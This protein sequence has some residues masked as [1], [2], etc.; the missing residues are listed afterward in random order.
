MFWRLCIL[1][2]RED[3][4]AL[5]ARLGA[6]SIWQLQTV[7]NRLSGCYSAKARPSLLPA[8]RGQVPAWAAQRGQ[9]KMVLLLIKEGAEVTLGALT[10]A[11]KHGHIATVKILLAAGAPLRK[12]G[13]SFRNPLTEALVHGHLSIAKLLLGVGSSPIFHPSVL[14]QTAAKGHEDCVRLLL[15]LNAPHVT[16]E[17]ENPLLSLFRS[18]DMLDKM[19]PP[20]HAAAAGHQL[21][22][23]AL[24]LQHGCDPEEVTVGDGTALHFA[25][26]AYPRVMRLLPSSWSKQARAST[27]GTAG[28]NHHCTLQLSG[29]ITNCACIS[30]ARKRIRMPGTRGAGPHCIARRQMDKLTLSI[31]S[32]TGDVISTRVS[33]RAT[34]HCTS[35]SWLVKRKRT[36]CFEREGQTLP[37][38]TGHGTSLI[39]RPQL[40]F[41]AILIIVSSLT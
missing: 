17:M 20:L 11:A 26:S 28:G 27:Q 23:V 8:D 41:E 19:C 7:T 24:L 36:P 1:F 29:G 13:L 10:R 22:I 38:R 6:R 35:P 16:V 40:K 5:A 33:P 2:I 4:T 14:S 25:A 15:E 21:A 18:R 34:H 37:S 3:S 12:D 32:W 9:A 39:S 30:S 31:Y